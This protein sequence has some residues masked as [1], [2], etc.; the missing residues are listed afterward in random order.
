[1]MK[2]RLILAVL[3][4]PFSVAQ[5]IN[6]LNNP[7]QPGDVNPSEQRMRTQ[8]QSQQ[9]QQKSML[10]QQL[11]TQTRLQQQRLESQINTNSQRIRE[12]APGELNR[13]TQQRL[14]NIPLKT[15]G[16]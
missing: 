16:P 11:Q 3:L 13:Q 15:I 1:M 5:P 9:I 7:N 14:P 10:S 12:S 6:V 2:K 4:S 8:M